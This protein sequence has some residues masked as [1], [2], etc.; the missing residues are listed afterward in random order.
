M[1]ES[2]WK[3]GYFF[4]ENKSKESSS[5]SEL[6]HLHPRF[7]QKMLEI[8][9]ISKEAP[10]FLALVIVIV[11]IVV[12]L[13]FVPGTEVI[14]VAEAGIHRRSGD[15]G[16]TFDYLVEFAA[17]EPYAP[18]LWAVIDFDSG[19]LGHHKVYSTRGTFHV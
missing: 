1:S 9:Y 6:P 3:H 16:I 14:L 15:L 7:Q 19:A 13:F 8:K 4:P 2:R 12:S 5:C 11:I 18:A 10:S 17:V